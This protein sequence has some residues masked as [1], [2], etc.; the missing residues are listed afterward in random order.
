[1]K[2]VH[3]QKRAWRLEKPSV[4][5]LE[6][7][8]R[9]VPKTH[10]HREEDTWYVDLKYVVPVAQIQIASGGVLDP[11]ELPDYERKQVEEYAAKHRTKSVST[12]T[13]DA[14][15]VLHLL[16]NAPRVIV[17]AAWKALAREHHPDRGGDIDV[18]K[19]YQAAYDRIVKGR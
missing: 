13:G 10:W 19:Q 17:D 3:H 2:F 12:I 4:T 14:Y 16:P 1:M 5:A 8:R 18:F 11:S 15:A 9:S 6:Y 7:L